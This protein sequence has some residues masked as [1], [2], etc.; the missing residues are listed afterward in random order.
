[1]DGYRE[2]KRKRVNECGKKSMYI[3]QRDKVI[4]ETTKIVHAFALFGN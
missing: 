1:M 3:V 2:R 4:Y